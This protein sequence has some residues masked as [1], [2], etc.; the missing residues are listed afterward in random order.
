METY[1]SPSQWDGMLST[2][3]YSDLLTASYYPSPGVSPCIDNLCYT[4][5]GAIVGSC[6]ITSLDTCSPES[7]GAY[8]DTMN[9]MM[10]A[11][12]PTTTTTSDDSMM[13]MVPPLQDMPIVIP[14]QIDLLDQFIQQH[15]LALAS[16]PSSC[17]YVYP[18]PPTMVSSP[19]LSSS[20]PVSPIPVKAS[21]PTKKAPRT[22][23][24][25]KRAPY[26][27]KKKDDKG[28]SKQIPI[29]YNCQH[30]G[31]GKVFNR[32]YNLQS[33]MRTHTTD[34]P[35]GCTNCGRRFARQHDRNRHEKLHWG[36]KPYACTQCHK[37]FARVDAL[38]RHLKVTGGCPGADG[39]QQPQKQ[40][41]HQVMMV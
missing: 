16:Y 23:P 27:R 20:A 33:H 39:L 41:Y 9:M 6:P 13:M 26:N 35:F 18:S 7:L 3:S 15:E 8:P 22:G 25:Q 38:N 28:D 4:N 11:S 5:T 31:C 37:S 1:P 10:M 36:I 19:S 12:P 17:C 32:P 24:R 40:Q 34:R 14:S 29:Q 21:P 30:P 2:S